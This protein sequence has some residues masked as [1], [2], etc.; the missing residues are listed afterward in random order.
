MVPSSMKP[1]PDNFYAQW[2]IESGVVSLLRDEEDFPP[3]SLLQ[4]IWQHQ[5]L[6][7]DE[8]TTLDGQ[9]VRVLHP[10]FR[11]FE[12]GPDFRGAM[13]QLGDGP[14]RSGDVEVDVRPGG[15][16]AHGHHRNPAFRNVILHVVWES[17]QPATPLPTL[18]LKSRL[19]A[20][21]G[22]LS[23]WLG[24]E[25]TAVMPEDCR[26]RCRT[27]LRGMSAAKLA[28][29]LHAAA[30][31]RLRCKAAELQARA[32]QAGWE[33]ALWEGLFRALGFKHNVWPMQRLGELRARWQE[34]ST[35]EFGLQARL[36]GL[37]GLLPPEVTRT[38]GG[39]DNYMR[40]IW[41][42]WWRDRDRLADCALPRAAWRM[43]GL[44][45][46]NHPHRRLALAAQWA[47]DRHLTQRIEDWCAARPGGCE[48]E[49]SRQGRRIKELENC[50]PREDWIAAGRLPSSL[51]EV[52][53]DEPDDFWNWHVR[54]G[55]PRLA[56]PLPLLGESRVTD[57]AVNVV[58]PWLWA[59]A[60]EGRNAVVQSR[61]EGRYFTWP[62]GQD[63]SV[64]RLARQRMLEGACP[65]L[66]PGAAA[67]QGLMQIVRDFCEHANA[68][69]E[70]CQL[71]QMLGQLRV[72]T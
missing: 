60:V 57:L 7:R 25:C 21:L 56:R 26:G 32:R 30:A 13:V 14:V 58:L 16:R 72:G 42:E 66:L 50:R 28:E 43:H 17:E 44:R 19:D 9:R 12:G 52:F 46:G 49:F 5:R 69:C 2:R 10:G 36:F 59:R 55:S 23:V 68:L 70:G 51:L 33:Q 47:Q 63:N 8:L 18:R 67:Q 22:E 65:R 4:G 39:M 41:D 53:R 27:V 40:R 34:G 48:A 6:L 64:L 35:T 29:L 37:S 1:G 61:M 20:P 3:E 24:G 31:V 11:S 38:R 15:W 45:P 62:A 54:L 71:P